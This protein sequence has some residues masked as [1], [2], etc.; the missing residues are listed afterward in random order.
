MKKEYTQEEQDAAWRRY[1]RIKILAP[2]VVF[3]LTGLYFLGKSLVESYQ[4]NKAKARTEL[5]IKEL[6]QSPTDNSY[7]VLMNKYQDIG[8]KVVS[9]SRDS[10]SCQV[11]FSPNEKFS[12]KIMDIYNACQNS[13][14]Q[15]SI[16]KAD[17]LNGICNTPESKGGYCQKI[18]TL[19]ADA[20][21][22]VRSGF[23]FNGVALKVSMGWNIN[24]TTEK[25]ITLVNEGLP[26]TIKEIRSSNG[27]IKQLSK[28][29]PAQI[30]SNS[31]ISMVVPIKR[32][33][34]PNRS[35]NR[36]HPHDFDI[37]IESQKNGEELYR[38]TFADEN[39]RVNST[40]LI[41]Q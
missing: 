35:Y 31:R 13:S 30:N 3:S 8:L 40:H 12:G 37:L 1:K 22:K 17:L 25:E 21:F 38:V 39:R 19:H 28:P 5:R 11:C 41:N 18:P 4:Q 6:I 33:W 20:P 26:I 32:G 34:L 36:Y 29:L 7:F 16:A 23:N 2:I 24:E 10:V 27:E 9:T 14:K 15:V